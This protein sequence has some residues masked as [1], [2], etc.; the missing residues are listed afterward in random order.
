MVATTNG[1]SPMKT[2]VTLVAILMSGAAFA[3][4]PYAGMQTRQIKAFSDQQIADL[5]AGRGMGL[6]LPAE[7]NGYPG[8]VHILELADPLE[9]SA[10]QKDRIQQLFD[11]MKAEA[12]PVGARLIDQEAALDLEFASRSI[13]PDRLKAATADIG[14]TQAEL[15]NTHLKYHLETARIL[16]S[17]QLHQY[18][19][20]RGYA[21]DPMQHNHAH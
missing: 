8:P 1:V 11:A 9:L 3:Q 12:L 4:S 16:S 7:L 2:I 14:S 15:R 5:R 6:A 19:M 18:A 10:A 20:L 17:R 13:T 21:T